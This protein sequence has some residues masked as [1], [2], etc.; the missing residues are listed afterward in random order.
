MERRFFLVVNP[1]QEIPAKQ[2]PQKAQ[3]GKQNQKRDAD[4]PEQLQRLVGIVP[5]MKLEPLVYDDSGREFPAAHEQRATQNCQFTQTPCMPK[6]TMHKP[7][8]AHIVQWEK[9]R[10]ITSS[11]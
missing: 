2:N 8:S 6:N 7:P 10:K 3:A 11:E 5:H 4:L 9:P 1:V